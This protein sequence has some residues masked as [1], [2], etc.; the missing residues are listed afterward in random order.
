M[1]DAINIK[2]KKAQY[3]YAITHS[4]IAGIQL[5][6][7]EIKSIRLS[8]VTIKGAFCYFD[9]K[10]ELYVKNFQIEPLKEA[11]TNNHDPIR[12]KKLLLNK[13]E[14]AAIVKEINAG[15]TLIVTKLFINAKGLAKLEISIAKGKKQRDKKEAIKKKDIERELK[16][17]EE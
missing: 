17:K 2:N 14:L 3:D 15:M 11:A 12:D 10:G 1:A 16:Q 7:T 5:F 6:G 8:H 4:Y 9:E 13:K